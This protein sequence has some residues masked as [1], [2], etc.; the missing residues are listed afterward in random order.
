MQ[1]T[2]GAYRTGPVFAAP[3]PQRAMPTPPPGAGAHVRLAASPAAQAT[4]PAV[5]TR[6]VAD[7]VVTDYATSAVKTIVD[8]FMKEMTAC[9]SLPVNPPHV[10]ETKASRPDGTFITVK[11]RPLSVYNNASDP[12]IDS[13]I[14]TLP[15][16]RKKLFTLIFEK[17]KQ[18]LPEKFSFFA[19]QS[20]AF[21]TNAKGQQAFDG[22]E[23]GKTRIFKTYVYNAATSVTKDHAIAILKGLKA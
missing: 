7:A 19:K 18:L 6:Q 3:A 14:A 17:A 8:I 15:E 21:G 13:K 9:E 10:I 20:E 2:S 16:A 22:I 1:A 11:T 4:A 5:D 23:L 12:Q